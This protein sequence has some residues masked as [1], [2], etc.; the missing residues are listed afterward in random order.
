MESHK[1]DVLAL[2]V[3]SLWPFKK[4]S[5]GHVCLLAKGVDGNSSGS[6]GRQSEGELV[7]QTKKSLA[8]NENVRNIPLPAL[9]LTR[10]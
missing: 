6:V 10:H 3:E 1:E 4:V 7:I 9:N 5:Y 2:A 8:R